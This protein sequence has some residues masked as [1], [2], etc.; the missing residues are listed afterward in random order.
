MSDHHQKMLEL[1]NFCWIAFKGEV[2]EHKEKQAAQVKRNPSGRFENSLGLDSANEKW[3]YFI[4][5]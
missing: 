2:K 1:V 4:S 3:R 5:Q